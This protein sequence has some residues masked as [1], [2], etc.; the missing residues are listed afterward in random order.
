MRRNS[1]LVLYLLKVRSQLH[2]SVVPTPFQLC[3]STQKC[4]TLC[5]SIQH[6]PGAELIFIFNDAIKVL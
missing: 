3:A 6:C 4:P 5:L 1:E 2:T